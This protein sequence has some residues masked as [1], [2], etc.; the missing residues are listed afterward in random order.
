[1]LELGQREIDGHLEVGREVV[2]LGVDVLVAVG[3][4]SVYTAAAARHAGMP[5]NQLLYCTDKKAAQETLGE[6]LRVGD[7]VL[8]KGSRSMGMEKI[9]QELKRS[10]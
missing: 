8:V 7:V 10:S 4:L 3:N 2:E 6:I 1:M 5:Q 9:V